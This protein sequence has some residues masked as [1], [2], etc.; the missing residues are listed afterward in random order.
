MRLWINRLINI[1]LVLAILLML[2]M[3]LL[4]TYF[5][6]GA[7]VV[8]TGSMEPALPR[9]ALAFTQSVKPEEI[10]VGDI[11]AFSP[12]NDPDITTSHRVAEIVS[13]D[14]ELSFRTKGDANEEVDPWLIPADYVRGKVVFHIPNLGRII[15]K[16]LLYVRTLPGLILLIVLPSV[17][18]VGSTFR[19]I[20][21][22]RNPRQRR[23]DLLRKR[24]RRWRR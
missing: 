24:Q 16:A 5:Q 8:L 22:K 23:L 19:T 15:N 1:V 21:R 14:G 7:A 10:K 12:K 2:A 18:I 13:A 17:V 6:Q 9:G 4:T 11:I 3:L 20:S